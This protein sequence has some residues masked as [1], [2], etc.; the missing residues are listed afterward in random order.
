M[1]LTD[2][3]RKILAVLAA[4]RSGESYF[5]GGAALHFEPDFARYSHDL[6]FF[7]DSAERVAAAFGEDSTVLSDAG[8]EIKLVFS[9]PGFIRALVSRRRQSTQIDWA[10]DSAWRFMPLV[11]DELGGLL[12]HEVDLAVNKALALAGRDEPRDLVDVLFVHDRILPAERSGLGGCGQGSRF[13][14]AVAARAIEADRTLP[15]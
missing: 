5:A 10:H 13:H 2:L 8:Y 4:S 12:L 1:P 3:Q 11:R 14:S 6:D 9:Q 15:S 7:H